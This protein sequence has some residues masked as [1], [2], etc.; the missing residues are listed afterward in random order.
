MPIK[1]GFTKK[2]IGLL[3]KSNGFVE[4]SVGIRIGGPSPHHDHSR[5]GSVFFLGEVS[6]F[7]ANG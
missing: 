4:V 3:E 5:F 6:I 7:G 2:R 1:L